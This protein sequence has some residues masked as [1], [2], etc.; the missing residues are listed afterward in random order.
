MNFLEKFQNILKDKCALILCAQNCANAYNKSI[1]EHTEVHF[2]EH[3]DSQIIGQNLAGLQALISGLCHIQ[4][5]LYENC[6]TIIHKD[7]IG[8]GILHRLSDETINKSSYE[9]ELLKRFANAIW[10]AQ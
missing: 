9:G 2:D 6:P 5:Y 4:N 3:T 8:I 7:E 1:F 10:G